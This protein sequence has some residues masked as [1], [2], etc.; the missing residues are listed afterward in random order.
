M[1]ISLQITVAIIVALFLIIMT[2]R[3]G[4][5]LECSHFKVGLVFQRLATA[6]ILKCGPWCKAATMG[7]AHSWFPKGY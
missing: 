6:A 2:K 7:I 4:I 1:K 5:F 3:V